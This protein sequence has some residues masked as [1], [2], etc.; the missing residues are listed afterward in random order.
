ME[1][2]L[3]SSQRKIS[4]MPTG[5]KRREAPGV[6]PFGKTPFQAISL[7]VVSRSKAGARAKKAQSPA[8][9]SEGDRDRLPPGA[10][11]RGPLQ[12]LPR[13]PDRRSPKDGVGNYSGRRRGGSRPGR[14]PRVA[15][16]LPR[17][18]TKAASIS[19]RLLRV[20]GL[21]QSGLKAPA[22]T[23][24]CR[25]LLRWRRRGGPFWLPRLP[26]EWHAEAAIWQTEANRP[27]RRWLNI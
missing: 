12:T 25:T 6:R 24:T 16:R 4:P 8:L 3:T 17:S 21:R 20:R 13:I 2:V 18:P 10:F 27:G 19:R 1:R 9:T 11:G 5:P 22:G 15:A 26:H 23:P 7:R 14:S